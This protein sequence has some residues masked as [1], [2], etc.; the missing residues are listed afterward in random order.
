ML[1]VQ[2]H[3]ATIS[4]WDLSDL[5]D[6]IKTMN[7]LCSDL[8]KSGHSTNTCYDLIVMALLETLVNVPVTAP[9][10][11][12]WEFDACTWKAEHATTKKLTWLVIKTCM[13]GNIKNFQIKLDSDNVASGK[14]AAKR[15]KV[16]I[17]VG[18]ALYTSSSERLEKA[19]HCL[20]AQ[21]QDC[22]PVRTRAD[23]AHS[24]ER[25][26]KQQFGTPSKG[27]IKKGIGSDSKRKENHNSNCDKPADGE[28]QKDFNCNVIECDM[29]NKVGIGLPESNH[30]V[31]DC[32]D[33]LKH[34]AAL[35]AAPTHQGHGNPGLKVYKPPAGTTGQVGF[36]KNAIDTTPDPVRTPAV[37]GSQF[38]AAMFGDCPQP[39]PRVAFTLS[40]METRIY[41]CCSSSTGQAEV[42]ERIAYSPNA[43]PDKIPLGPP[44]NCI[45][46]DED[47]SQ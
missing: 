28:L 46:C 10:C 22:P 19:V 38:A 4:S 34:I 15:A 40:A 2:H 31:K 39:L 5:T 11:K 25:S 47:A 16:T 23:K 43:S 24:D 35:T 32:P 33:L 13:S 7:T 36:A 30:I 45:F 42:T 3:A 8:L 44:A 17:P 6:W 9:F 41:H 14:P 18:M 37:G 20:T 21:L 29:C 12:D 1:L 26:S 27:I